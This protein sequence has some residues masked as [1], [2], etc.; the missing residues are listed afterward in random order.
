MF[1]IER[2]PSDTHRLLQVGDED[3][4]DQRVGVNVVHAVLRWLGGGPYGLVDGFFTGA[5]GGAVV[6]VV[7]KA[8]GH[9]ILAGRGAP[10]HSQQARRIQLLQM[11]KGE[12]GKGQSLRQTLHSHFRIPLLLPLPLD[13][14][15]RLRDP[16][17]M[18]LVSLSSSVHMELPEEPK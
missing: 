7:G 10:G 13:T 2:S 8:L 9:L 16:P 12:K 3:A 4:D 1:H 14:S 15:W 11:R 5:V 6:R 17:N 18:M